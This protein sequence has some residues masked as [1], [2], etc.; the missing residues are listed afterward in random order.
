LAALKKQRELEE[1]RKKKEE[2]RLVREAEELA[3]LE[4]EEAVRAKQLA[5]DRKARAKVKAAENE[6]RKREQRRQLALERLGMG[7]NV[8]VPGQSSEEQQ[9]RDEARRAKRKAERE[10]RQR[11]E[12]EEQKKRDQDGSSTDEDWDA[13]ASSSDDDDDEDNEN[14]NENG[15][16]KNEPAPSS[17][18]SA[19]GAPKKLRSPICCVLG[20]VDTGKTKLLDKIRHTNVQ[21]GEAGGI[22]QQIGATYFPKEVLE[23][24]TAPIT[25]RAKGA[26][27]ATLRI[28]IPGL[29]VIDTPGHESFTNLR[30]RGSNL[31]D[32]AILVVDM[33]HSVEQQTIE[34]IKLLSK[35]KVPFVI[36]LNK[37]DQLYGWT[38]TPNEAFRQTFK[39]QGQGTKDQ[40]E[41]RLNACRADLNAQGLNVE[42]YWKN[43]DAKR[44]VSMV[45]TSAVTGEGVPDL[46]LLMAK[47]TQNLMTKQLD[48]AAG[49]GLECTVLEVKRTPGHGTTIDVI[50]INGELRRGDT[51]VVCGTRG[52]IVTKIRAL[53]MPP[54][55]RELR[56]KSDYN[57]PPLVKAAQGIKISAP[58]LDGAVPGSSL[59]VYDES[60]ESV[61]LEELKDTVQE[62]LEGFLLRTPTEDHGVYV[63]ASTLGSL[64]A[65]L[66]FLRESKIPV[67]RGGINIGP[68]Y[69]KD[70]MRASAMLEHDI[71]YAVVLA[72]DVAVEQEARQ[73]ANEAGIRIFEADIIYHLFDMFTDYMADVKERRKRAVANEAVF[74]CIARIMP[75][76]VFRNRH[77]FLIGCEILEGTLRVGTPLCAPGKHLDIGTVSGIKHN[78]KDVDKAG[79]GL[80][81]S[82]KIDAARETLMYGRH[83]DHQDTLYSKISRRSIDV[84]KENFRDELD[85]PTV[86]LLFKMKKIFDIQ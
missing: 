67:A 39:A 5:K 2:A 69:K 43:D 41:T 6:K 8:R 74:P 11:K 36:A 21:K 7:G 49:G 75:E 28:D 19:S 52:A 59:F 81:V 44:V 55:S 60:D 73:L 25:S 38:A 65:L 53:L 82:V 4:A 18:S 83:F 47:M 71:T 80:T 32:I 35:R 12:A 3:R 15:E 48:A 24:A 45:P 64:E 46:L 9:K 57:Q 26:R 22:T 17:S 13:A 78:D 84:L 56:V 29:L 14:N 54:P 27:A 37:V 63:Q 51:I 33:M 66:E 20:H 76:H 1:Q 16:T 42:L 68:I 62:E 61:D 86:R 10:E 50:L 79:V 40:F 23:A 77:P 58:E 72:F 34:S 85:K 30:S 70:I 31:C